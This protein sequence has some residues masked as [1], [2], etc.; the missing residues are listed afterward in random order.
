MVDNELLGEN[1]DA[2]VNAKT[3]M[4]D[5]Y[6]LSQGFLDKYVPNGEPAEYQLSPGF[7]ERYAAYKNSGSPEEK[8]YN[9]TTGDMVKSVGSGALDAL[10][11]LAEFAGQ[12]TNPVSPN[13]TNPVRDLFK[14]GSEAI[15]DSMTEGGREAMSAE[16]TKKDKQGHLHFT[17]AS[18]DIDVWAMKF[19]NG[20]G[21]MAGG[22]VIPGGVISKGA[23]MTIGR[24]VVSSM[25]KRGAS[26]AVANAT[27]KRTID[28]IAGGATA[29]ASSHGSAMLDGHD[30]VM[31]MDAGWLN[32]NSEYFQGAMDRIVNDPA[33]DGKSASELINMAK[34]ETASYVSRMVGL[35]PT[36]ITA[37]VVGAFGDNLLFKGVAGHAASG[38]KKGFAKGA[39]TEALTEGSENY[40]QTRATN[41]AMN[42]VA[43]TD[44]DLSEGAVESAIEGGLVGLGTG[45]VMGGLGGF[46]GKG[47]E[48]I[49]EAET[50]NL[51]DEG[52]QPE[53]AEPQTNQAETQLNPEAASGEPVQNPELS[54]EPVSQ[55]Q[56]MQESLDQ[57]M[58]KSRG[59]LQDK[60]V[61]SSGDEREI[62]SMARAY[63]P[64]RAAQIERELSDPDIDSN[65]EYVQ[66]LE[67]EYRQLADNARHMDVD[68][69]ATSIDRHVTENKRAFKERNQNL[70]AEQEPEV[71]REEEYNQI[72]ERV[73]AQLLPED[74][75]NEDLINRLTQTEFDYKYNDAPVEKSQ[76]Y[77]PEPYQDNRQFDPQQAQATI[78][79]KAAQAKEASL[80]GQAEAERLQREPDPDINPNWIGDDNGQPVTRTF[81]RDKANQ[82]AQQ[83]A[84][85]LAQTESVKE[86]IRNR[87]GNRT[88]GRFSQFNDDADRV[89]SGLPT[90]S[91][92][93]EIKHQ[94]EERQHERT[95]NGKSIKTGMSKRLR[96]K[97]QRARG[98]DTEA[99]L[100]E[101]RNNEKRLQAYQEEARQRAAEEARKHKDQNAQKYFEQ[102]ISSP[103]AEQFRENLITSS[104]KN[105]DDILSKGSGT[106]LEMDGQKTSLPAVKKQLTNSVR[107]LAAK[108]IG[109]TAAMNERLR[110]ANDSSVAQSIQQVV[111]SDVVPDAGPVQVDSL[112][113]NFDKLSDGELSLSDLKA[114]TK[115]VSENEESIKAQLSSMTIPQINKAM[116]PYFA[117]R[118]K[119][120][121]KASLVKHAFNHL[122]SDIEFAGSEGSD[123]IQLTQ[124]SGDKSRAQLVNDKIS[125]LSDE[126]YQK[127]LDA[128]KEAVKRRQKHA[129][130][131]EKAI[132]D[133][134]TL[135]DFALYLK[136]GQELTPELRARY[137]RL[138][139]DDVLKK[140]KEVDDKR[141]VKD[142]FESDSELETGE[143]EEGVHGKTGDKIFNVSLK[144]RLGKDKFKEA[145]AMARSMK[146]GYWKGSFYFPSREDA[147]MF[148]GWLHGDSVDR[149]ES[150]NARKE[151]K[152]LSNAEKLR[153]L[154][155]SLAHKAE[156]ELNAPRLENT[157]KRME[158]AGRARARAE[159]DSRTAQIMTALA[160]KIEK[161]EVKALSRLNAKTQIETLQSVLSGALY[162]ANSKKSDLVAKTDNSRPYWKDDVTAD[163]RVMFARYPLADT[164]ANIVQEL[165][166]RMSETSGYKMAGKSLLK[167]FGERTG[168]VALNTESETVHKMV[169][170]AK[171]EKLYGDL[172]DMFMR[173]QRMGITRRELLREA[174]RE[175]DSVNPK[176]KKESKLQSLE[177]EL[178]K[179]IIGNRNAFTD[180]F[181]TPESRA[182]HIADLADIQK[183]MKV[184]EPSAGNGILADAAKA[185][186]AKVDT[187]EIAG[188]L[189]SILKEKGHNVVGDDFIAFNGKDYDR[190]IMNPPFSKD[191]DIDH[192]RHAYDMLKPGGRLVA[193]V[194]GMA[195]DRSNKKNQE[196]RD[197]LD[198]HD[199]VEEADTEGLFKDSLNKTSVRTKTITIDKPD[200]RYSREGVSTEPV[201][202]RGMTVKNAQLAADEFLKQYNGG[203]GVKISVVKTQ[204]EAEKVMGAKFPPGTVVHALYSD[205]TGETVVVADN[206]ENAR[207]LRK[208][209]RHEVLVHHGLKAVVGDSEYQ[210]ILE[211][212]MRGKDSKY[213]K[214]Y[215]D[216]VQNNYPGE[217]LGNQVEEVLA[218][219]AEMERGKLGQWYDR[220][221]E[222]ISTALKRVGLM[223]HS[224]MTKAE[225]NNIIQTLIDR[226]KSVN[227]WHDLNDNFT[228][229]RDS[230]L[231]QIKFSKVQAKTLDEALAMPTPEERFGGVL[232]T[233]GRKINESKLAGAVK[234]EVGL[235][236]VTLRQ[237]SDLAK[238]KL[239]QV[240]Q[241]VDTVHRMLS[242]RNQL[243]FDAHEM[244]DS[245]RKWMA[246]NRKSADEMFD[247]AH[248]ATVEGVDPDLE[249]KSAKEAIEKRIQH[250]ENV[251]EG[252]HKTNE[253]MSEL[254]EL[255][256]ML[257]GEPRRQQKHAALKRRFDKL[258]E[259]AKQHYRN[260][261]DKYK[262]RHDLYKKLLEEQIANA[263]IDGRLKK[264][265]I[266]DLRSQFELQEVMAPYFPL[267]RF[268]DYWVSVPDENGEKRFLMF[269]TE[270]EQ[271][272]TLRKLKDQGFEPF[273]GYKLDKDPKVEGASLGFVVDL[274]SKVEESKLNDLKKGEIKDVIYQMY[275]QSL[276][277][278]SMRKQFMHRQKVKGW[279][280]DALRALAENMIKGSYQLARLEFSDE[281]TKLASDTAK[282]AGVSGDNQAARYSNELMKRH[283]WVMNPKHNKIAQKLTSMGFTWMLGFSPAAAAINVSQ[284]FVVALPMMASKFGA[285]NAASELTKTTKEFVASKGDIKSKLTNFEEKAAFDHWYDSGLL[286]ST[287]AH[288]LAGMAEGQSWKYNPAFEKY[289]EWM[290]KLFHKAEV[291]NRETT[292]LATYR[293]A[294]KNGMEHEAATKLAEKLTWDA[295][296]DYSN[297]NRARYMQN[298]V[299]KVATQF[300]QYSQ[301]MTYFLLRNAYQSIKGATKEEQI[302]ARKQLIGSLGMTALMGGM[303]A[304]PLSAAYGIANALSAVFGDDDKP[305]DAETEFRS[306]LADAFGEDLADGILYGAGGAGISP[307]ISM[308]NMWFQT[309]NDDVDGEGSWD[310]YAK[311][312][313]G[314]VLGGIFV[315]GLRSLDRINDGD[316]FRGIEGM[317]PKIVKDAMKAYR[318]ADEGALNSRGDAYKDDFKW[319]EIMGQSVGFTPGD[320]SK[321]YQV[322]NARKQYEQ[323][324]LDRRS[325]LMKAYYLAW[326]QHD[327]RLMFDTQKAMSQFNRK[328]PQLALTSQSIRQA[329]K[330]RMRYSSQSSN[331]VNLN[332]KLRGIEN[333][334]GW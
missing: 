46:R 56:T 217:T 58:N 121:R 247:V 21:S 293:L 185:K 64:E 334:V 262:D 236:F 42:N 10:A 76:P 78:E 180:F 122:V 184:L 272:A 324:V 290:S 105:I 316:Y 169:E 128:K 2:T 289:N 126:S 214:D 224:D 170:F 210:K 90:K 47:K 318:Y 144:T 66:E 179:K 171:A 292:A 147:E 156:Q 259:E 300:K 49:E 77:Q 118:W 332:K 238:D 19:A 212:M 256:N 307:R 88:E 153:K 154:G 321:Q 173:L 20:L 304:L 322:N 288:D 81:M 98:F 146:G 7:A 86:Q 125:S 33:N 45:G 216:H 227:Q 71:N 70:R 285:G 159:S 201:T 163:Q 172:P 178:K 244:A 103:E 11:G 284:N 311:Q 87:L 123:V 331:G 65:P 60:G 43:G 243:A 106:V 68:P 193:I 73:K 132:K 190:I 219:A 314:P 134:Q 36:A 203:A 297:V 192:V 155:E 114:L 111:G 148:I 35:D 117:A 198:A 89:Q 53:Q 258:P 61:L 100:S 52:Y 270:K 15:T 135:A 254:K 25:V 137:D 268:G 197:W 34:Q 57:L 282:A 96:R 83:E 269:E 160:D 200:I 18:A 149:S 124:A 319:I 157:H 199:A 296:F 232:Q 136:S 50:T 120:E 208:K 241:Y 59:N 27:A 246:R 79:S 279:S 158:E 213:L 313:A 48:D 151:D 218:H 308:D 263:A 315:Q 175:M 237:L 189:R 24:A 176:V 143:I 85:R 274:M 255:R 67:N 295:H 287:N 280:N 260:M 181:P 276:P 131:K 222:A 116:G 113:K 220:V 95:F 330:T 97:I 250:L 62:V 112:I 51:E 278:R 298:P 1:P 102:Q 312:A 242:R 91:D 228:K 240:G 30:Q 109:K 84:E 202:H 152:L 302:E 55:P 166:K 231:S 72:R 13:I 28:M 195:G 209:L 104:I 239:P 266:A 310:F 127:Y 44:R 139:T 16:I 196:F 267:S 183:G 305:W 191:M 41:N 6:Q 230:K 39:V 329:I 309:P 101:F 187:V 138:I 325:H 74:Q 234:G 31:S 326:K 40:F 145:A 303:S 286:D 281:L 168:N 277:S 161:G 294:R 291:F 54:E 317:M 115:D 37:S 226:T 253:Q 188:D 245:I 63:D 17:D 150:L 5:G 22:M 235:G 264:A 257:A 186:G 225:M 164:R 215:W 14:S 133:P 204:P 93:Q 29:F 223:R 82:A 327:E 99:V 162:E 167:T 94:A 221:I 252:S 299:M 283:E 130:A 182:E 3:D 119:G 251:N 248:W 229:G 328:Y 75:G 69:H 140:R 207:E 142:G 107:N 108:F 265:R 12:V 141:A 323:H 9:A 92:I 306:Y 233:L 32:E 320:L 275:L 174:I 129:E 177:R 110:A 8:D 211:R 205:R 333:A 271:Q 4:S 206:I 261:R 165:G 249:F 26:E 38:V 23:Q 80:Q 194:S 301:N 273:S